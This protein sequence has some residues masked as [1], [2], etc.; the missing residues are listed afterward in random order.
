MADCIRYSN[1]LFVSLNN[2]ISIRDTFDAR[3]G[4][5]DCQLATLPGS[6][7]SEPIADVI[8]V[9]TEIHQKHSV[10]FQLEE[11]D[12]D[13]KVVSESRNLILPLYHVLS[14]FPRPQT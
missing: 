11:T 14:K 13:G 12:M 10:R 5:V 9:E 8:L 1:T 3:G 7:R 6:A 4:V 2:R